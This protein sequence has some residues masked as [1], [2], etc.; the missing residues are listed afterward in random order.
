LQKNRNDLRDICERAETQ[1]SHETRGIIA[2]E[3][4]KAA[5]ERCAAQIERE[6][7]EKE[8]R[9][10]EFE[11]IKASKERELAQKEREMA[12]ME[13]QKAE[14]ERTQAQ[15]ER[16]KVQVQR[17]T[18]ATWKE[19]LSHY[20]TGMLNRYAQQTIMTFETFTKSK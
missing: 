14:E 13:R 16:Q 7:A 5:L 11:R 18:D 9:L 4:V 15:E 6:E 20:Q 1:L 2:E 10:T 8:R 19:E 3:F 17:V 12:E